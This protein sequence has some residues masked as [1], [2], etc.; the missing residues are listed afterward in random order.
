MYN[1]A[2]VTKVYFRV[3]NTIYANQRRSPMRRRK[4][5]SIR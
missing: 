3:S 2:S 5:L 4:L 1:E